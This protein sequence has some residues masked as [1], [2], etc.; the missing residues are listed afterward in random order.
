ML[1][2]PVTPKHYEWQAF[3]DGRWV[4]IENDFIIEAHYTQPGAKQIQLDTR[5]GWVTATPPSSL[6]HVFW[7]FASMMYDDVFPRCVCVDFDLLHGS[8]VASRCSPNIQRTCRLPPGQTEEMVWYFR[9]DH[10][11]QEYGCQVRKVPLDDEPPSAETSL[12]PLALQGSGKFPSSVSSKDIELQFRQNPRGS[13]SFTVGLTRYTLN[14]ASAWCFR[15]LYGGGSSA[16]KRDKNKK[17]SRRSF[18]VRRLTG[19]VLLGRHE[20]NQR[21]HRHDQ[22]CSQ[23]A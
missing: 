18:V 17:R 4:P 22:K 1:P 15:R 3:V 11:W 7:A 8:N 13:I 19:A 2:P 6:F 21:Y 10:Q 23:A 12:S 5:A 14:L 16:E 20:S 9:D